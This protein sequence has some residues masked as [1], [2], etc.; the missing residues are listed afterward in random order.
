LLLHAYYKLLF[1]GLEVAWFL[2]LSVGSHLLLRFP[3]PQYPT[4]PKRKGRHATNDFPCASCARNFGVKTFAAFLPKALP[5]SRKSVHT[6]GVNFIFC[7]DMLPK[8]FQ[9][10]LFI[11]ICASNYIVRRKSRDV[12]HKRVEKLCSETQR[13]NA[14]N[15]EAREVDCVGS[16]EAIHMF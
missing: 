11:K 4:S 13:G 6:Y 16:E 9:I 10:A 3:P 15:V 8:D 1:S 12:Y 2:G 7:F 5:H 14:D